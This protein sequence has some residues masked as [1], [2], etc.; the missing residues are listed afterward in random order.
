MQKKQSSVKTAEIN[1]TNPANLLSDAELHRREEAMKTGV[2]RNFASAVHESSGAAGTLKDYRDNDITHNVYNVK[3][4][5]YS[6]VNDMKGPR[7]NWKNKAQVSW[8]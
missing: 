7:E 5:N 4:N 8:N 6:A 2:A 3:H 1:G